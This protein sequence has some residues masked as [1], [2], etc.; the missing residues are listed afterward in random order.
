MVTL[1]VFVLIAH[2]ELSCK[3]SQMAH[4]TYNEENPEVRKITYQ[5][6]KEKKKKNEVRRSIMYLRGL[7]LAISLFTGS[8]TDWSTR[9]LVGTMGH[10][11][12]Q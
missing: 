11:G 1:F 3:M 7:F 5:N 2:G 6:P 4:L 12:S 10:V 9:S 8:F